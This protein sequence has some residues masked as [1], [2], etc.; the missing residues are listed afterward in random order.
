MITQKE[1]YEAAGVKQHKEFEKYLE[2][3]LFKP[4]EREE[5]YKKLLDI[6][7]SCIQD[8]IF[9][10]Y[11]EEYSAERKSNQQDYTPEKVAELLQQLTG[12]SNMS[13]DYTAGTGTLLCKRW[14]YDRKKVTPFEYKPCNYF[15][16]AWE[17]ADNCVPYLIHNML[18]RGMNGYV[19]HGDTLEGKVKQIYFIQNIENDPLHFS[20]LNIMLHS[21][22][23]EGYFN[24]KEWLEDEKDY[25]E[26]TYDEF[27]SKFNF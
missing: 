4:K 9:R 25:K 6:D 12:Q 22:E 5:F 18:I 23:V 24:I 17:L 10:Q 7:W 13:V 19:V 14:E 26:N 27:I 8:D 15:Y 3:I 11:F 16:G 1:F 2:D 21:E 20:N